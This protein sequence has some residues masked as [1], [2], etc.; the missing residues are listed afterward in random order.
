MR[1]GRAKPDFMNQRTPP[2]LL[3]GWC[4]AAG[5][6]LAAQPSTAQ[7]YL[8]NQT[9][10]SSQD[11]N[12]ETRRSDHF[13]IN[14]GHYNRDTGTAMTEQ[15]AQGNLQMYE[16][17]WNRWVTE[18]GMHDIN[19][20]VT[21]PDGN[22]YRANFN[23]LMT[24]DDGGGGGAWSSMDGGGFFYAMANTSYAR[25]DPPSGATP[26]EFGHVWEGSA[27]GF[28]GSNSSGAWWECTANWMQLQFLNSYPQAGA[29][30]QNG[31]YYPAHG[32]DY[33]DSW[34][35]WET[36]REDPRY[37]TA[38]VNSMWSNATADQQTNE[39]I[40]DRMIRLD[41]SGSA[42]KPG[43]MK[44]LW[45][46]MAKKLVTWDYE[47][48]QWLATANKADDGTDWYFYQRSR[49]PLVKLPGSAT[50]YRPGRAHLPM[51]FGFNI[52]PLQAAAGTTVSCGFSP[53]CDPVR[54]SD[55]RAC[56]VAVNTSGDTSYST[57]WNTGTNS[58]NLSADQ[59][60]LYLV[61]IATPKPVKVSDPAWRAYLTDMGLQFP[62][63]VSFT[64][65][66]P[67]NVIYPV[68]S[69]S[70]MVQHANGGGWKAG[71][72]S[73]DATAYL[74]P[75]AQVLN[76]AQV[77]GNARIED[78]AVVRNSAQVRDNAVVSGHG[79]VEANAQVYGNAKVRDWG[80]VFGYV[81]IY[82]NA[83]VIEHGNC[84]EGTAATHTKVYGN[85]IVK[86]TSYV[87]NT[88]T[89][90]GCLIMDGD[91]ANGNGTTP[92]DHGVHFG[93]GWGS[94]LDR[95]GA[96]TDN[97]YLYVRHSFEKD[98]AVFA[99]DEY[100]INHGFL[101]NG[102]R[103]AV[104]TGSS[105]RGGRV[106]PLD[107][108]SQY[109][110]LHNSINDFKDSTF[111]VWF[112]HAGG[113]TEQCLWSMGNGSNK[114]MY[115][116]P[117]AGG[118]GP[119][120]LV[121]TDGTTS[122]TLDGPAVAANTWTHVAVVFSGT[123]CS[124]YVNGALASGNTAMTLFPD[125]LNAPL[126]ENNNY[127]GRGNTGGYFHGVLDDFRG[128]TKPLTAAEVL[129]LYT[130]AAPG[131]VTVTADTTAPS[132][133]SWLVPPVAVTDDTVTMS[134]TPGTDAS[135][136]VEY[137]FTCVAGSG[138]D[139]G[140]VSFN[141]YTDV[142]LAPGMSVSYTVKLRDRSGNTTA[143]SATA[144]VTGA[145]SSIGTPGF[146][147][148]P[149]GIANGQ[150]TMSATKVTSP[151]GKVE[152][153]FDRVSPTTASSGWQSS[154]NWTQT[155][156]TTGASYGYTV[157][158]R[159]N[160]GNVSAPCASATAAA[161]DDAAPRLCMPVEHWLMQPYATI[162]NKVSMTAQT[163]S[164]ASGVE[165][166]FHCVSGGGP[167]SAWQAGTTFV[168]PSALPDGT[169]IYQYKVRDK[170]TR[171]NESTYS[172]SYPAKIT[173]ITGY[174]TC[175]LSQVLAG[176]DDN[177]V[178]FPAT[179]MK[180]NA[181]NYQVKDL[182]N[183]DSITVKPGSYGLVTDPALALKNM[184]VKGHLYTFSGSKVI[185][186][187]TLT[188]TGD[189]TLYTISGKVSNAAGTG[190]AGATVWFSDV[191]NASA[192]G[193]VTATTDA[194][195]NYSR[196]VTPGT[197][198]VAVTSSAYN[199]SGDQMLTINA[200][201]ISGIHFTLLANV[202]VTGTVTRRS[203]GTPVTG[204][205]VYFSRS[206]GASGTA[207]FTT[208]TD[209][210]GHYAQ[211]VQDGVWYVAAAAA[212]CYGSADTTLNISGLPVSGINFALKANTRN[213][214]RTADLLFS[215][216]TESLPAS[217]T[218]STWAVYQP[219]GQTLTAMGTP[220]VQA[221]NGAKWVNN[222]YADGDG[223]RLGSSYYS[224]AIP[225]NGATIIVAARPTRN[226]TTSNWT[227]IVDVFY[228]RLVL[229][230]R[231]ST[232]KVDVCRN[233]TWSSS[234]TAIP[235]GQT[236]LLSLV[237]QATG[238]YK[239]FANGTQ[240]MNITTPSDMTSLVPGVTGGAGGYGS[241]I[242][243]GRNNPDSWSTFN[244]A[245]GD[246]F[247]YK[248]ALSDTAEAPERQQL[249]AD[250]ANKFTITDPLITAAA[251]TGGTINPMGAVPVAPGGSQTFTIAPLLG[252]L[253]GTVT[254]DGVAQGAIGSYTF[255]NVTGSHTISATFT[256]G[257]ITPL[258][259]D[260]WNSVATHGD[261]PRALPIPD[262]GFIEPRASGIRRL[263]IAFSKPI[264]VSGPGAVVTVGGVNAA[265]SINLAAFG[266]SVNAVVSNRTLVLGFSDTGGACALPDVA[267]WRFTLNPA[268]I[269]G[270]DGAI[271]SA[272]A[273]TERVL[274]C[275]AGDFDG[276]GRV[277][278][279]DLNAIQHAGPFD[280]LLPASLRA[281]IDG[282]AV[283]APADL[284]AAWANRAKRVDQLT[285]P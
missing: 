271:L 143:E 97:G 47:R 103:T 78:Y 258:A 66:V 241:Y 1:D 184:T 235:T 164:D 208:T 113:A 154:P 168:T 63:T 207:V 193:I 229:G 231:N 29:Y 51:E 228:N 213:I 261:I 45:G 180:V 232:G 202:S 230:I 85:A 104:D 3:A 27:A 282:D 35:I 227:S 260:A 110:E 70:G 95:F 147:Y 127:L 217:G 197:W 108:A 214:P 92:T 46:D 117:N 156:L 255:S 224:S 25:F 128:Y 132:A 75:N 161:Q 160:R 48:Q 118:T 226:A 167:D 190:I 158:L 237:V 23:V 191:A 204:A 210:S 123:T 273:A 68:Q 135:G 238:E 109:V 14:F 175:T 277:S 256:T 171:N 189:P 65:A 112:K 247:V 251:S 138:H 182:A 76:S 60:K 7:S 270:V 99:M 86:G 137:Y 91:S 265:G 244:G 163:A 283:I 146:S 96:L 2:P 37:G 139:S 84:G 181:D 250:L 33:Y 50:W 129:A 40:L 81:E 115:L 59:T 131:T 116:T 94:D 240:I 269:T 151:G 12:T 254:V 10:Y 52:I 185:T 30:I 6:L 172:T 205:A 57:L 183:G 98:N 55:W 22:K 211:A 53:Q 206:P 34:M 276:N 148:G 15:L 199:T 38:W 49:T 4:L 69:H 159:D 64:N 133:P 8:D 9:L 19:E 73:V 134:A 279:L 216:V 61:V 233:G 186:Y 21:K 222:V 266:I 153:K 93:W 268:V 42:D 162:D 201:G 83:K 192:H 101:M 169:Y 157:T 176:A 67:K 249:E 87:Y 165:Y 174:H 36:A 140:W 28:N 170:S 72:A 31:M 173:P 219:A 248:V 141:K 223:F 221:I 195:G 257:T 130:S 56:L 253:I 149:I 13:R 194:N 242:N 264:A 177:L 79:M 20:S 106:L 259:V 126:M 89:F 243:V 11:P 239:V 43:A 234:A 275:L 16:Q 274:A 105:V 111:A 144:S 74:G 155:G 263:E 178:S 212:A 218:I 179:V 284:T 285:L 122:Q 203:D 88:S 187:A 225:I 267:K 107:G 272:S 82:E 236:T 262:A 125:S 280:P 18:L 142:G 26:H 145:S 246:I 41:S 39:F 120:R 150:I 215:A 77:K 136:W 196:G 152:Y 44:D 281:D 278:G 188:S 32:R 24:W 80:R 58:I 121:I 220:A 198:Y 166:Y 54:Q 209:A 124:L 17:M 119:L 245:I 100:G 102:C 114:V 90:N 5:L 252:Q 62:Y 200:A 71:T